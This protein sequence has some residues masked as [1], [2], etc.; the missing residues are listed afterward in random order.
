MNAKK[1]RRR[2]QTEK[3][4][5]ME[6]PINDID[7]WKFV[8]SFGFSAGKIKCRNF[9]LL[10]RL[11]GKWDVSKSTPP[12]SKSTWWMLLVDKH[13]HVHNE[14]GQAITRV[15]HVRSQC[16]QT[17]GTRDMRTVWITAVHSTLLKVN[18]ISSQHS[19]KPRNTQ[20]VRLHGLFVNNEWFDFNSIPY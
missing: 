19:T 14:F 8:L 2:S 18:T 15:L 5:N 13:S 10:E 12:Q 11:S 6:H 3:K 9:F 17:D 1:R 7:R 16:L 4:I 20:T